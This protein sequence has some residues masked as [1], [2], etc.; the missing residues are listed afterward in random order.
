MQKLA[1]GLIDRNS[2]FITIL[3]GEGADEA[4]AD[5]VREIFQK[6]AKDAEINVISGGQPVY[7][8]IISVES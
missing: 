4:Q 1:K 5:S 3:Y 7:S 8:Y 2:S 6:E